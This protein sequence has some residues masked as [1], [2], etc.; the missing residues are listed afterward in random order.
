LPRGHL[1]RNA[2]ALIG[3]AAIVIAPMTLR[4]ALVFRSFVPVALGTG[5]ILCQGIGDYDVEQRFG[6]SRTDDGTNEQEAQWA[7][8]PDY[9]AELY[10]P[11]GIERERGRVARALSVI[12]SEP[13]WFAGTM[14]RRVGTMLEYEP[15]AIISA[16]PTVSHSLEITKDTPLVWSPS[17]HELLSE[18]QISVAAKT[19]L[20]QG[21]AALHLESDDIANSTQLA[22]GPITIRPNFDYVLTIPVTIQQGRVSITVRPMG[23]PQILASAALPD[24][25][26][27]VPYTNAFAPTVQLPFVSRNHLSEAVCYSLLS[28][29]GDSRCDP[30]SVVSQKTVN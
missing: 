9:A 22:T 5:V 2:L 21:D 17:P 6:L 27:R 19:S 28:S 14:V 24:S 11:D 26:E 15:V 12:R 13:A 20:T 25:L 23:R 1:R 10:R 3:G 4:N 29:A 16:D 30:S 8:R 7:G 18:S